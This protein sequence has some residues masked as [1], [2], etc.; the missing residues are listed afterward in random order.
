MIRVRYYVG[1]VTQHG[2]PVPV[3]SLEKVIS[4]VADSYGGGCTVYN[5]VG[6]WQGEREDSM[7]VEALG[8]LDNDT[9]PDALATELA[10]LADQSAVLWTVETVE[11]G[12]ARV[13]LLP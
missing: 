12:F 1:K 10:V 3:E 6:Y 13:P 11:G 2:Q 5:A 7:V 4:T 9:D 8:R